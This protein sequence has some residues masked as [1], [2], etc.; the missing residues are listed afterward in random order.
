M[1]A[2]SAGAGKGGGGSRS[3]GA[4]KGGAGK[5]QPT[6]RIVS[7]DPKGGYRIDAPG[8]KRASAKAPTQRSA[9]N[10]AKQI[11]KNLGGGEVTT[12]GKD[13]R[14]KDSDTIKPGHDPNPPRD[15]KH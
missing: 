13:G 15:T 6:R 14:I 1:A 7:P 12:R 10:R 9:Q 2:R 8:A 4:P 3:Q 5:G 11:V